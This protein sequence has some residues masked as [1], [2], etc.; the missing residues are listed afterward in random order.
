M[1]CPS[2]LE[3]FHSKIENERFTAVQEV[4]NRSIGVG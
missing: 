3:S 1:S 4:E 2:L